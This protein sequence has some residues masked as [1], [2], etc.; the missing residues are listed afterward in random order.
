MLGKFHENIT[1]YLGKRVNN[2][3]LAITMITMKK[4][5]LKM[6]VFKRNGRFTSSDRETQR[7]R[8]LQ[9]DCFY[10]NAVYCTYKFLFNFTSVP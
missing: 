7:E 1:A 2:N 5:I 8:I 9:G 10:R 3:P 6:S 4:L